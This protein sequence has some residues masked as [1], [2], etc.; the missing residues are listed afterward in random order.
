MY[1]RS[2]SGGRR[3]IIADRSNEGKSQP[4]PRGGCGKQ[5]DR[6]A[7][8]SPPPSNQKDQ[9]VKHLE[10][11]TAASLRHATASISMA[12]NGQEAFGCV[13]A[14]KLKQMEAA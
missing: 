5:P 3:I 14:N 12:P 1:L 4:Q 7:G 6:I 2:V 11:A 8:S 9:E 10:E 13:T